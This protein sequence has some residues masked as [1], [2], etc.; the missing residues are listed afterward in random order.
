MLCDRIA[1]ER[2]WKVHVAK[3][4]W[5]QGRFAGPLRNQAMITK[6]KPTIALVF[7]HPDSIGTRDCLRRLR[8]YAQTNRVDIR[9]V[10]A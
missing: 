1:R 5:K 9:V 4:D 2:G 8:K 10:H 3:A 7:L 6:F